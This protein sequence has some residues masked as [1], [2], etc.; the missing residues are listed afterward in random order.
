MQVNFLTKFESNRSGEKQLDRNRKSNKGNRLT[1][2]NGTVPQRIN[3]YVELGTQRYREQIACD[4]DG[5]ISFPKLL[6]RKSG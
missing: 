6:A 1:K 4:E 2:E 5:N 3:R